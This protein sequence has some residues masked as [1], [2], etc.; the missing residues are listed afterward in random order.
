M[1]GVNFAPL[2]KIEGKKI[3]GLQAY[4]TKF[5]PISKKID[6][7]MVASFA[8]K[9]KIE[10]SKVIHHQQPYSFADF[11]KALEHNLKMLEGKFF[12]KEEKENRDDLLLRL[13]WLRDFTAGILRL[14]E[15]EKKK[16]INKLKIV[17]FGFLTVAGT[18]F[19]VCEGFDGITALLGLTAA[20]MAAL[21][22]VGIVFGILS[23][24]VFWGFD[25]R[26]ISKNLNV[27]IKEIPRIQE[28]YVQEV[29][30]M[31]IIREE[32]KDKYDS[33]NEESLLAAE[34]LLKTMLA[35]Y[36]ALENIRKGFRDAQN[37][38][39]LIISKLAI[40]LVVGALF[41]GGGYFAG[42]GMVLTIV[43]ALVG[44]V[45]A[46]FWPVILVSALVGLAAF[47]VYWA[48]QRPDVDN[49]IGKALGYDKKTMKVLCGKDTVEKE[50]GTFKKMIKKCEKRY[51]E[52]GDLKNIYSE[53]K[54]KYHF[55]SIFP[56]HD[57]KMHEGY[58]EAI[59]SVQEEYSP[60]NLLVVLNP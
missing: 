16:R 42:Q 50:E 27:N 31:V 24:L 56:T 1:S 29:Q 43:G 28:L 5:F 30:E 6:T 25:V 44:T 14:T 35:R 20:P 47:A 8:H 15:K 55:T 2:V 52:V 3:D 18:I 33:Y 7:Q 40:E 49:F 26:Q 17:K 12:L 51:E 37:N 58:Q 39:A 41:F 4:K 19:A 48:E 57:Q 23:A 22:L 21:L 13:A 53:G 46:T 11:I 10:Q 38:K 45:S 32:I 54:P 60:N 34:L 59:N 36:Q 9:K